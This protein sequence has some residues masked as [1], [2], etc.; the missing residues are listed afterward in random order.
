[1]TEGDSIKL[2]SISA[3]ELLRLGVKIK[4]VL[5]LKS[6]E[7]ELI[8]ELT[9]ILFKGDLRK[10]FGEQIDV[11]SSLLPVFLELILD[12]NVEN[13]RKYFLMFKE[14]LKEL[15]RRNCLI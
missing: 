14:I 7:T 11:R 4:P 6:F 15:I 1:M 9:L 8:L 12:I 10:G 3:D 13:L 5:L 2:S